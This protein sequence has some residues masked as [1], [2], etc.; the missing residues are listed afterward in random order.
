[1]SK[2]IWNLKHTGVTET[3]QIYIHEKERSTYGEYLPPSR[4]ESKISPSCRCLLVY[5]IV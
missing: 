2:N 4:S 1:M 5:G 3:N